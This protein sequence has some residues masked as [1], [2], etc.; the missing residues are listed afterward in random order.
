[1]FKIPKEYNT[2]FL[3]KL[4]KDELCKAISEYTHLYISDNRLTS[5]LK[6]TIEK[7][8]FADIYYNLNTSDK[9]LSEIVSG[10]INI[11]DLPWYEP[12]KLNSTYWQVY[13]DKQN[14]KQETLELMSSVNIFKCRQCGKQKCITYQLQT[15]SNDEPMTTFVTCLNCNARW[16]C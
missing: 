7:E 1:M 9:L 3:T 15:R 2:D 10:N 6:D 14:K 12:H 11:R 8:K 5:S 16:K 4:Q 13:I